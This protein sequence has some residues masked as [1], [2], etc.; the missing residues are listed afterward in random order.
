MNKND[1]KLFYE[2]N[3]WARDRVLQAASYLSH[4]TLTL[5]SLMSFG[6]LLGT[7]VHMFNAEWIWRVRCQENVSPKSMELEEGII[8]FESLQQVWH[9]EEILMRSYLGELKSSDLG[10]VVKYQRLSGPEQEN[11]LWHIL[12]HVVNHGTQHRGEVASALTE[13]GHSPGEL[14]FIIFLRKLEEWN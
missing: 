14:D 9:E 8:D 10:R 1:L 7:L 6:S 13:L 4:E 2:Y 5:P 3:Y 11:V 12:A